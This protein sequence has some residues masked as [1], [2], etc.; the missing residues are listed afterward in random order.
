MTELG[1]LSHPRSWGKP[2]ALNPLT[3]PTWAV[4][5][6]TASLLP[7]VGVKSLGSTPTLPQVLLGES[8]I[9]SVLCGRSAEVSGHVWDPGA[10]ASLLP[11]GGP[12]GG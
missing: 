1:C 4:L 3:G 7:P 11:A 5:A 12:S 8:G 10:P 2:A 9:L 6:L